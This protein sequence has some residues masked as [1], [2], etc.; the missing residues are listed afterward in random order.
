MIDHNVMGFDVAVHDAFTMTEVECLEQLEYVVP[1]IVVNEARVEGAEV[2]VVDV[3]EDQAR[4][5]ALTVSYHVE[6]GDD[7]GSARQV[8]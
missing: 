6:Q 3:L 8:L 4:R 7:I 2:G 1:Y 5:L